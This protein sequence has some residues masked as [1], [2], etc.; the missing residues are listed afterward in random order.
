[1]FPV[2][3]VLLLKMKASHPIDP[4]AGGQEAQIL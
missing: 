4:K 1:M 2:R 3:S